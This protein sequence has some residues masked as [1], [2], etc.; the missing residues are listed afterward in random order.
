M[1][2]VSVCEAE[3]MLLVHDVAQI[4]PG[5]FKGRT[6]EKGHIIGNKVINRVK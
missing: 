5:K 1:K 6:F 3:G 4:I 2:I